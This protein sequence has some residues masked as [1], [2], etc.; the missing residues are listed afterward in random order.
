[1]NETLITL[2]SK[3]ILASTNDDQINIDIIS[4]EL[5]TALTTQK[6]KDEKHSSFDFYS[7]NVGFLKFTNEEILKMPKIFRKTFRAQGC[8]AHIRKR[9]QGRYK[10][11]YEIRYAKKPY[12]NPPITASG[13]TI[14]EAKN[15]F[16]EKLNAYIPQDDNTPIIPKAFDGFAKYWFENFHKR[17]VAEKTYKKNLATYK[18]DIQKI[19]EKQKLA[20]IL[21]VQVQKFLE[22][23]NDKE[24]TKETLHS[25]LNQIF[26]CAVKH[27]IIKLNPIDMCFYQKHERKHGIAISKENEIKLL[28]TYKNT[29]YELDFAIILY[30]GLRP[31]EYKTAIIDGK[32]IKAQ[33]SKRKGGKI[34]YKRIPISPMLNPFLDNITTIK[35]HHPAT[36]DDRLKKVLPNHTLKDM[37]T[38]FQTRCTEH[39]IA[40]VAIGM[41]MGNGI[42]SELKKT[43]TNVSDEWLI[44]EINKFSY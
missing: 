33:N 28:N 24:R 26:D 31:C 25:L 22:K 43:Y 42:G 21:P 36:I 39:K 16:I 44:K 29:P 11:S 35:L 32:F 1:M 9:T 41:F 17:K 19:F 3:L 37:R 12:N 30:T 23:F 8:T 38:T 15:K 34:E 7:N 27:G 5:S 2:A 18:H 10:C 14:E 6:D 13:T 4:N 40:E 20:D